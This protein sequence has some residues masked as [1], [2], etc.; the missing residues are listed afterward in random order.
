MQ[1]HETPFQFLIKLLK[2]L[3][4]SAVLILIGRLFQIS[5]P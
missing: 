4:F 2:A 3:G 1:L 5:G